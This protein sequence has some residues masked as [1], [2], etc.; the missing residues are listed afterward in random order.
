M[1]RIHPGAMRMMPRATV[2]SPGNRPIPEFEELAIPLLN[3]AYNLAHWLVRND[4]DAEDLVQE[5]YLKAFRNFPSFQSGTNF[6]AW[7]Y[8]I[9]RN[10]YLTSRTGLNATSTVSLDS[11]EEGAELA[12]ENE[13]PET[14]LMKVLS[15][16][17]IASAIDD[18]PVH[19]RETLLLC[20]VEEISY[21]EIAEILSIPMGT[22]MSRLA[23]ARRRIRE[24]LRSTSATPPL[25]SSSQ[26][27]EGHGTAGPIKPWATE[28]S[29]DQNYDYCAEN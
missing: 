24:F 6:R 10:T 28:L 17:L 12:V 5:T 13:T 20:D 8:R 15:S 11:E 4:H 23:R 27:I 22:V 26:R 2:V 18:L 3:S 14:A 21:R 19:Y 29:S 25:T 7:M 1:R 16:Q 9:L